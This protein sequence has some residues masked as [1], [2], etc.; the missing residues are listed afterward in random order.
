M[1]A[2]VGAAETGDGLVCM[3]SAKPYL[4]RDAPNADDIPAKA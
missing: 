4:R 1:A 2:A 3:F